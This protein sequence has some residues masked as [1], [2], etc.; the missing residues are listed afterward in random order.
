MKF[1]GTS[2]AD[3][4][5]YKFSFEEDIYKKGGLIFKRMLKPFFT[6]HACLRHP[7][8]NTFNM[9][10]FNRK[11]KSRHEQQQQQH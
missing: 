10:R 4:S 11:T 6:S 5:I 7:L 8:Q 2:F 1:A 9:Y 3:T